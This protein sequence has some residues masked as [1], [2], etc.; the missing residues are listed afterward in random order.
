MTTLASLNAATTVALAPLT[1]SV[2]PV[3]AVS[4]NAIDGQSVAVSSPSTVVTIP[5]SIGIAV[6]ETYTPEGTLAGV[7]PTVTTA[8]DSRDAVTLQMLGS[9]STAQTRRASSPAS[10]AR[11][12]IASRP[13]ATIFRSRSARLVA[14]LRHCR[15][16]R[17]ARLT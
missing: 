17:R 12:S 9:Y 16:N 5:S 7:T 4:A 10:A 11:C 8:S 15:R 13:P 3:L 6:L 1:D 2:N 14:S